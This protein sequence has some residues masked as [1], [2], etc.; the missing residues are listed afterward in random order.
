MS[1]GMAIKPED[2]KEVEIKA[3]KYIWVCPICG[4]TISSYTK[5]MTLKYARLHATKHRA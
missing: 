3:V 2:V 1:V 4:K 5:A